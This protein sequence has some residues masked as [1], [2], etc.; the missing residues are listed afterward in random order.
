[1]AISSSGSVS[2]SQL[3]QELD[4]AQSNVNMRTMSSLLNK[5]TP[6][7]ISEFYGYNNVVTNGLVLYLDAGQDESYPNGGTTWT[8]L[9]GNGNNGTLTNGPTYNSSNLG[10]IVLDGADDYISVGDT[11]SLRLLYGSICAWV[12]L[13]SGGLTFQQI[14]GKRTG[15]SADL[16]DYMLDLSSSNR[17]PRG[18][19]S[20]G[21]SLNIISGGTTLSSSTWYYICFT[22][23]G[24]N[25]YLYLNGV[26]DA[27][28]VSQTISVATSTAP[29]DIGI[30]RDTTSRYLKGNI[31]NV[32][33]YNRALSS[34]EVTQNFNAHRG[35]FGI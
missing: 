24:S 29:F 35:R 31:S 21:S 27:S 10:N 32:Q 22:W 18:L 5:T 1:M 3:T 11:T 30:A 28:P 15:G 14:A 9:S 23:N 17:N 13:T 8:D 2:F 20:N 12:Y 7:S 26:Q 33:I 16:F 34:T 19:I 25:L 6:D 4:I